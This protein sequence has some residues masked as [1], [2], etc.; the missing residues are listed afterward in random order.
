M[1]R[2]VLSLVYPLIM[3]I[4]CNLIMRPPRA[5]FRELDIP[6]DIRKE[7]YWRS[8]EGKAMR[9]DLFGDVR[10]L[11]QDTGLMNPVAK[12]VWKALR[13]DGKPSRY[14]GEPVRAHLAA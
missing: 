12:L 3:F 13:I 9:R 14:R 6:M 5:M 1:R 7:L 8:P 4:A 2:G 10:M 11:A